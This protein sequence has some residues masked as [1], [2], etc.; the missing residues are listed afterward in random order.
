MRW[1][2]CPI[3]MEAE[4]PSPLTPKVSRLRL[5]SMAPV[6]R[7]GI[8]PCTELKLCERL[9][10]YAGLFDEH[11][12]PLSLATRS[13]W[14]PISYMAS[15]MR[16][17]IALCPQPAQSVVLPPL[18][19]ITDSPMRLILGAGVLGV[20]AILLALHGHN[21]VGYGARIKRQPVNV[22]DAAQACNQLRPD[23]ELQ[24]AQH[25]RITVL[26]DNVHAL[27]LL[28]E[29]V[30][31]AGEGV[32]AQ[33][34]VVGLEVVFLLQLVAALDECPVRCSVGDDADFRLARGNHFRPRNEGARR[35]K[36][37]IDA[38]HVAL[39]VVGPFAVL[40]LFV[41]AAAAREVRGRRMIGPGQRAPADSI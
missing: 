11:P 9:M 16:S 26:L 35:F 12:M 14:M 5:A 4:S 22:T 36:L 31:F 19:S 1:T 2:N 27:V 8:R 3:P 13:G 28:D 34:Q 21:L 25:L 38:L 7:D 23:V 17:D 41:V 37:P 40:R 29:R 15:M 39:E 24:Q 33:A 6:A 20:V 30:H 18:Y 32:S 10:K